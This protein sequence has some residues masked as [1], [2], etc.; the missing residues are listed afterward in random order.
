MEE[1]SR[2][3]KDRRFIVELK[4][5][6][7]NRIPLLYVKIESKSSAFG[8]RGSL[9][10]ERGSFLSLSYGR[11]VELRPRPTWFVIVIRRYKENKLSSSTHQFG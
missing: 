7:M 10:E 9:G 3:T 11:V 1:G 6:A 5:R 2:R 4:N 8:I